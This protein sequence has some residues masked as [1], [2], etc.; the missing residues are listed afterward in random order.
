[1]SA[2]VSAINS[3]TRF[4]SIPHLEQT[5]YQTKHESEVAK[6]VNAASVTN[7]PYGKENSGTK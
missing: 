4:D 3:A 2:P 5:E 1:L 7:Q 6:Q